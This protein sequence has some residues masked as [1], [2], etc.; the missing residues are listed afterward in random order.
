MLKFVAYRV[1]AIRDHALVIVETNSAQEPRQLLTVMAPAGIGR[2]D[3]FAQRSI[4]CVR[5]V[6][7]TITLPVEARRSLYG[8]AQLRLSEST[9]ARRLL[10]TARQRARR[11]AQD[12]AL[13][14]LTSSAAALAAALETG[15]DVRGYFAWSLLDK[16]E[17]ADG[18][19]KR[20]GIVYVD[21]ASAERTPKDSALWYRQFL[22]GLRRD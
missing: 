11:H 22:L 2:A 6:F 3:H 12:L 16:F 17:W 20:F 13:L 18:F 8:N 19:S 21:Y 7:H 1:Q 4:R 5:G 14:N 9:D 10:M 15:V